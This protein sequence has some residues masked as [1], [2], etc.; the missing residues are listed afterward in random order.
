MTIGPECNR[1]LGL[2]TTEKGY[3]DM[4][5]MKNWKASIFEECRFT[6][7]QSALL[8]SDLKSALK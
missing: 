8:K 2:F 4:S 6:S 5:D 7:D 1:Q 3:P